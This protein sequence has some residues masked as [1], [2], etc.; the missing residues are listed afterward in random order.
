MYCSSAVDEDDVYQLLDIT[1]DDLQVFLDTEDTLKHKTVFIAGFPSRKFT[2]RITNDETDDT[3]VSSDFLKEMDGVG[4]SV[5]TLS[6]TYFV[7]TGVKVFESLSPSK[8]SCREYL[9][10]LFVLPLVDASI[11][12]DLLARRTLAYA[13]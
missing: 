2:H 8:R 9:V 1:F 6:T 10:K 7:Y 3:V 13:L 5:P 11:S 12:E 4:L